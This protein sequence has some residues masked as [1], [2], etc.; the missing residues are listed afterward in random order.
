MIGINRTPISRKTYPKKA[1]FRQRAIQI[2]SGIVGLIHTKHN[3]VIKKDI[4]I[5]KNFETKVSIY[6]PR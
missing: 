5:K 2:I 4:T 6:Q 1:A 3:I